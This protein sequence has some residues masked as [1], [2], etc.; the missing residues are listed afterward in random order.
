M[1]FL[2]TPTCDRDLLCICYASATHVQ[3][4]LQAG[5]LDL[6]PGKGSGDVWSLVGARLGWTNAVRA[7]AAVLVARQNLVVCSMGKRRCKA[8][9]T[10]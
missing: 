5:A 3:H 8:Y 1:G 9:Q 7:A 10:V 4:Q 2:D 6:L